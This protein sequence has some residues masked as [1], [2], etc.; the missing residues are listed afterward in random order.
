MGDLNFH[1][2]AVSG[3]ITM[4]SLLFHGENQC[5]RSMTSLTFYFFFLLRRQLASC[6]LFKKKRIK[7]ISSARSRLPL[8]ELLRIQLIHLAFWPAP[9]PWARLRVVR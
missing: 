3:K 7:S 1:R 5:F 4:D 9:D 6:V 2:G 8:R